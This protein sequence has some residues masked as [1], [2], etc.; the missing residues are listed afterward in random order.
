M[1]Q[2][3][4]NHKRYVAGY[5]YVLLPALLALLI[6]SIVNLVKADCSNF[7]SASLICF[8]SVV[9]VFITF[10]ARSFALIAQNRVIRAEE[11]MRHYIMT[12][13]A[14]P[15]DLRM[16]QILA[17]RFA[18]DEEFLSLIERALREKLSSKDIKQ[19]IQNWRGDYHRV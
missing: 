10:Y 3:F 18:S 14:L 16:S 8:M 7:Y 5:H 15:S 12:G 6:G 17:L 9:L 11:N 13:K 1:S 4:S 2:N 19:A